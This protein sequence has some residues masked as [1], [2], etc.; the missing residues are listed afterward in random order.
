VIGPAWLPRLVPR[1]R[2]RTLAYTRRRPRRRKPRARAAE[3]VHHESVRFDRGPVE[4]PVATLVPRDARAHAL[5]LV[6]G[7]GR[8]LLDRW[9]WL[10]PRMIPVIASALGTLMVIASA[11]YL[12][13][14]HGA[15][16][17]GHVSCSIS[18][19]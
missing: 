12:T 13:H 4:F 1:T 8:W 18:H 15:P 6:G 19:R 14:A 3:R 5:A 17:R 7:L 9:S 10:R 16:I 2:K 11:E